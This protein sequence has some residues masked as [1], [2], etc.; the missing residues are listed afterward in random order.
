MYISLHIDSVRRS[1]ALGMF[2]PTSPLM[3]IMQNLLVECEQS[4]LE[5][6]ICTI[7]DSLGNGRNYDQEALY[8]RCSLQTRREGSYKTGRII[9]RKIMPAIR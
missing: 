8:M 9:A 1:A 2:I 4:R 6:K 5:R 3:Q 7:E